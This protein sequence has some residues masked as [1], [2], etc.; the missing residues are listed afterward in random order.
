MFEKIA[1]ALHAAH[2]PGFLHR[3]VKPGNIMIDEQGEPVVLDFGLARPEEDTG[4]GLTASA[5]QLGTPA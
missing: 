3:D 1:R 2:E 4:E 5:D